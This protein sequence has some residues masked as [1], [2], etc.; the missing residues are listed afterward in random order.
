MMDGLKYSQ[1]VQRVVCTLCADGC[2]LPLIP[3]RICQHLSQKHSVRKPAQKVKEW[4][5]TLEVL[6]DPWIDVDAIVEQRTSQQALSDLKIKHGVLCMAPD[7][8]RVLTLVSWYEH[9][10]PAPVISVPS[11][12]FFR[13][14]RIKIYKK[15]S[16]FQ[17][18]E[19]LELR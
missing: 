12:Y 11:V 7:C 5:S 14:N 18:G 3:R 9:L 10:T 15:S 6:G 17:N 8:C 19:V 13:K 16:Q 2:V 4:L 1:Q